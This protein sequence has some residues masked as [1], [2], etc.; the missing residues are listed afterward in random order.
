MQHLPKLHDTETSN[1]DI[2]WMIMGNNYASRHNNLYRF[3]VSTNSDFDLNLYLKKQNNI[4][5]LRSFLKLKENWNDYGAKPFNKQLIDKCI[6]LIS[7]LKLN[8]QPDIFPTGIGTIQFEYEKT[9][10]NYLEIEIASDK[11]GFL[12]VDS[13]GNEYESE[14]AKWEDILNLIDDFHA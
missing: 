2:N 11:M 13:L 9:D 7:S 6:K 3:E 14:N 10:G 12:R 8:Y 5:K 1:G 4:E